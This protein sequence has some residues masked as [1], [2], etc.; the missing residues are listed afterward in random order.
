MNELMRLLNIPGGVAEITR[1]PDGHFLGRVEGTIG[2]DFF[3]GKL[4]FHDG[5]DKDRT[6]QTWT[7]MDFAARRRAVRCARRFQLSPR[8]MLATR[9]DRR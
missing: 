7:A 9:G 2:F 8:E 3:L 6:R 4:N 5:P 1:T